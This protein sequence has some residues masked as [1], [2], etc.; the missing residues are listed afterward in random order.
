MRDI[1]R[2]AGVNQSTVSRVLNQP[3]GASISGSV[4]RKVLAIAR[5]LDYNRNPSAVAL[6]TGSTR[7]V[8]VVI[9]DITDAYYSEIIGGIEAGLIA[10]GYSMVLHSLLNTGTRE[11][12][13]EIFHQYRLDGALMLGALP[14]LADEA[15]LGLCRRDIPLILVGR[16]TADA[17]IPSIVADNVEG[18]RLAAAC[19][20]GLGHR[21]FAVMR[22]PRGWPDYSQ[23]LTGFRREIERNA[24][25]RDSVAVFPCPT[26][27]ME[28]GYEATLRLFSA[29]KPTAL[30]CL[31]DATAIGSMHAL[32]EIGLRVPQEVSVIGFDDADIARYSDPPLTTIRQPR[33]LMGERAVQALLGSLLRGEPPASAT[34]AVSLVE[35]RST[36]PRS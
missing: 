17:L 24:L 11:R 2:L 7:T 10:E 13:E 15:I 20:Y 31:N 29:R 9:S 23:R 25:G 26:R 4:R 12:L 30:F 1:A 22:G 35:R 33:R 6:R 36:C 32:R 34:L 5:R 21:S 18:G 14:G 16:R 28:A 27:G 3:G 8:L 19:L